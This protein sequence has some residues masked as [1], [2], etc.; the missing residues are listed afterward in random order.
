MDKLSTAQTELLELDELA[1]H[2]SYVHEFH[3]LAKLIVTIFYIVIVVS[4]NKYDFTGIVPMVLYPVFIYQLAGVPVSL[5]FKKLRYVMPLVMAVGVVNPFFDHTPMLTMGNVVITGGILSMLTLMIKGILSLMASFILIATTKID[6][7]CAALRKIHIPDI[8]V[9]LIL[10]TYR[11]ISVMIAEVSIMNNAYKL[12]APGQNGIHFSAWGS[13]LGQLL[14]RSM[15]RAEE[16]YSSMQL[17]GFKGDFYYADV[18]KAKAST[19]IYFFASIAFILL[20]RYI[21]ISALFGNA[22]V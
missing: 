6:S 2:K 8:L 17:R 11:Y 14:L 16:L 18:K 10:L 20:F 12:R 1:S 15:D 4:F 21:N 5:C 19:Y 22:L 13:F 7:L 9:T 3:P